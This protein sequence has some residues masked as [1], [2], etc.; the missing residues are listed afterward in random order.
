MKPGFA[1]LLSAV[2]LL[3]AGLSPPPARA[4]PQPIEC[5][6]GCQIITCNNSY[7]TL[8]KCDSG[9][10]RFVTSW[11]VETA[12]DPL[13][14]G[15]DPSLQRAPAAQATPP[16][17]VYAKVCAPGRDCELYQLTPAD[18]VHLGSFDNIDDAVRSV[19]PRRDPALRRQ[20]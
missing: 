19:Q 4:N 1:L 6:N 8:W 5:S 17:I 3:F 10:C 18:V 12:E 20:D 14:K 11:P 15:A 2:I 13:A 16:D 7:C 9:G